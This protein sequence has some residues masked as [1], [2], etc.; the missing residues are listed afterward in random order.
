MKSKLLLILTFVALMADGG[1][2]QLAQNSWSYSFGV[3]YPRYISSGI[4]PSEYNY[5]A[6]HSFQRNFSEH[7]GLRISGN[8]NRLHG[9]YGAIEQ[10]TDLLSANFDLFY[11]LAPCEPVSPYVLV[12][13]GGLLFKVSDPLSPGL[14]SKFLR[15]YQIDAGVGAEWLLSEDWRLQTEL[16]YNTPATSRI[17]GLSSG[18]NNGLLGGSYDTYATFRLGV[19]YYFSKGEPSKLCDIYNGLAKE[20]PEIDYDRIESIIKKYQMKPTETV[21]YDRIEDIVKRNQ[22][23]TAPER[24]ANWQLVGVTFDLGSAKFKTEA[25]PI[26]YNAAQMLLQNPD[27]KVEIQGYTDDIGSDTYNLNLSLKRANAVKDYLVSHG[28]SANRLTA[29][30]LGSQNPVGSNKTPKGR[31]L[32][33]RIEFKILN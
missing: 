18:N 32:N 4:S 31:V 24:K 11:Y 10:K 28:V 25:Y 8:Y 23:V 17:D 14:S 1:F 21:D 5:G 3:A 13:A 12:G 16:D 22:K 9:K 29:V 30:G 15:D 2:A 33:R 27:L 19:I 20:T 7:V 26:L 6:Y